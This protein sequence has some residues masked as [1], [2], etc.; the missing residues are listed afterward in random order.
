LSSDNL[1]DNLN[2]PSN[3]E[4]DDTEEA[5]M[6]AEE[7]RP[8]CQPMQLS[9]LEFGKPFDGDHLIGILRDISVADHEARWLRYV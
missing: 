8:A 1:N 4:M 5:P 2:T 3:Y 7:G 6:A 9:S